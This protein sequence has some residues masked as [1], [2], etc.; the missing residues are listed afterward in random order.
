M[1]DI[2]KGMNGTEPSVGLEEMS[3][4]EPRW[5]C[6]S[7]PWGQQQGK[8][9]KRRERKERREP[10]PAFGM[11]NGHS[12]ILEKWSRVGSIYLPK[13]SGILTSLTPVSFSRIHHLLLRFLLGVKS[14]DV[15][16]QLFPAC[17]RSQTE[18]PGREI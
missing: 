12:N 2:D 10:F 9:G 1:D 5:D 8:E 11:P 7:M 6:R 13:E 3:V 4:S 17:E 16:I 14:E 15:H 18:V